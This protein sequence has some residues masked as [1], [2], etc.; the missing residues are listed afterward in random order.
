MT[1]YLAK[2]DSKTTGFHWKLVSC[3]W[4]FGAVARAYLPS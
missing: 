4:S 3:I 1:A 2:T